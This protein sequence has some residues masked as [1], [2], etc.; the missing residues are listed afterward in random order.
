MHRRFIDLIGQQQAY[1]AMFDSHATAEQQGFYQQRMTGSVVEEVARLRRIAI[2]S[3]FTSDLQGI[4]GSTWF[5]ATTRRIDLLKSAEDRLAEDLSKLTNGIE[6]EAQGTLL[7]LVAFLSTLFAGLAALGLGIAGNI[8]RPLAAM[9]RAIDQLRPGARIDIPGLDRGDEIGILAR[10]FDQLAKK[11]LDVARL[12]AALDSCQANVMVANRGLEIVYLNLNMH[13]MLKAAE[14]DIRKE[15][16]HFSADQLLGTNIDVFHKN[17]AHQRGVLDNLQT[18]RHAKFDVGG[19]KMAF[20][21]SPVLSETGERLGT[22]VEWQDQTSNWRSR[23]RSTTLSR[24]PIGGIS[25]S[26]CPW[27]ASR[28]SC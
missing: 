22:V 9:A 4:L 26:V 17:P 16:P 12:K 24:P 10:A 21:A 23:R 5:D 8:S 20:A 28:V 25:A 7:A 15:L 13:H 18:T 2:D 27:R 1:I 3:P 19:R 6:T 14:Q 11:S